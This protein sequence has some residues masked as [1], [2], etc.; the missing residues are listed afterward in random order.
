M[1]TRTRFFYLM[2]GVLC[3][4]AFGAEPEPLD[5][6][7]SA[8]SENSCTVLHEGKYEPAVAFTAS[9][10]DL[11]NIN[12]AQII[13][14]IDGF[15]NSGCSTTEV[16][17]EGTSPINVAVLTGEPTLLSHL[18]K[19]GGDPSVSIQSARPWVDGLDSYEFAALLHKHEPSERRKEVLQILEQFKASAKQ[20]RP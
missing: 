13:A 17:S 5:I 16:D 8:L 19:K 20:N 15:A 11:P 7:R 4:D 1:L 10:H 12:K 2:A 18:L 3:L 14:L 6:L 9:G